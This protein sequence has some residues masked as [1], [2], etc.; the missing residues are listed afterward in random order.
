MIFRPTVLLAALA[1]TE[2]FV[3]LSPSWRPPS[4]VRAATVDETSL[5]KPT[6]T[7]FLPEETVERAKK[8]SP[9]EKIKLAKDGMSAFVDVYEYARQIR[10]GELTWEDIEKAD[11]DSVRRPDRIVTSPFPSL[12]T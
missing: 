7:S 11:L 3:P 12:A 2:A 4:A 5:T 6:G 8:G 9:I 10:E 1:L